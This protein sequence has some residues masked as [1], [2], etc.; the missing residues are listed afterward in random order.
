MSGTLPLC[1]WL[2]WK[3]GLPGLLL[4]TYL[5]LWL[6]PSPD[7]AVLSFHALVSL[8]W[9]EREQHWSVFLLPITDYH[10]SPTLVVREDG[11]HYGR[12][13]EESG[14][15]WEVNKKKKNRER[16]EISLR[17]DTI[18]TIQAQWYQCRSHRYPQ[19]IPP[20]P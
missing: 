10:Q 14:L 1:P 4:L 2:A 3:G 15:E 17:Y 6:V 20:I 13:G 18:G 7:L 9:L 16:R 8:R 19:V 11:G 5:Y 12:F